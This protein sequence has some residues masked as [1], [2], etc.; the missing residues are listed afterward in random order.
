MSTAGQLDCA[1]RFVML[2]VQNII[3]IR[4]SFSFS[5][6]AFRDEMR[7]RDHLLSKENLT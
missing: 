5:F 6:Y 7:L 3:N 2:Q 1:R 4:F